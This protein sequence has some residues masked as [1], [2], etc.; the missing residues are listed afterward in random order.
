MNNNFFKITL[1][2]SLVNI[3]ILFQVLLGGISNLAQAASFENASFIDEFDDNIVDSSIY[4]PINNGLITEQNGVM[5]LSGRDND[6]LSIDIGNQLPEGDGLWL[7]IDLEF[8]EFN[9]DDFLSI[10][11]IEFDDLE[12]IIN[13]LVIDIIAILSD[14]HKITITLLDEDGQILGTLSSLVPDLGLEKGK[15]YSLSVDWVPIYKGRGKL[16]KKVGKKWLLDWKSRTFA[17]D[18]LINHINEQFIQLF[19]DEKEADDIGLKKVTLTYD[20]LTEDSAFVGVKYD[21][22]DQ[23]KIVHFQR[24]SA[25]EVHRIPEPSTIFG[26]VILSGLCLGLKRNYG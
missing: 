18:E 8:F 14:A 22:A 6:G 4:S 3:A 15:S 13:T 19:P 2:S 20:S 9:L 1:F 12:Q 21:L 5:I 23:D 17:P 25:N 11:I 7:G 26:L 16:R 10:S 24:L